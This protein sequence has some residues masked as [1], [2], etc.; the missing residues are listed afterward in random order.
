[1]NVGRYVLGSVVVFVFL[2]LYEWLLH[3]VI[4]AGWYADRME[5]FRTEA[6]MWSFFGWAIIGYLLFAF[7]FCFI[8]LK[9]YQGKGCAE[10][11]RYGL[12]VGLTFGVGTY[13]VGYSVFP[14]PGAWVAAWSLGVL[15][16][17]IVAGIIFAA[18]YK[19]QKA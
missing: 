3:G 7:G 5:L 9:G 6:E 10:G 15:I 1:M 13:L 12:Y 17:M 16:E 4:L 11:F 18:I 14:Y 8:F 2:N 19:P